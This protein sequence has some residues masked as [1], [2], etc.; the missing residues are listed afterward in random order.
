M[1]P[2]RPKRAAKKGKPATTGERI[3]VETMFDTRPSDTYFVPYVEDV[4][5]GLRGIDTEK[6]RCAKAALMIDAAVRRAVRE[7]WYKG[8]IAQ[9]YDDQKD[10]KSYRIVKDYVKAKY[11]VTIQ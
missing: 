4:R 5:A 1:T 9:A 8:K 10:Q 2:T 11:G 6:Q 7:V 3:I